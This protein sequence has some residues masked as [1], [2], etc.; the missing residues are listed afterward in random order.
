M[1]RIMIGSASR[2]GRLGFV[3]DGEHLLIVP[4]GEIRALSDP[5]LRGINWVAV[6]DLIK[7]R[8]VEGAI[9]L[10][11]SPGFRRSRPWEV[12]GVEKNATFEELLNKIADKKRR[13]V[14]LPR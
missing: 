4:P 10:G 13:F 3:F 5:E 7:N 8:G 9:K 2:G 1:N 11:E 6:K 14:Y 12:R